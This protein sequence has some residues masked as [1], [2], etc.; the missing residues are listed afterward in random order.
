MHSFLANLVSVEWI[1]YI[2][3]FGLILTGLFIVFT[4]KNLIKIIIGLDMA[5]TG[6]NILIVAAGYIKGNTELIF[7]KVSP[8]PAQMTDP[9]PQ[10]LVLTS[11]VIGFGVT[12]LALALVVRLYQKTGSLDV[13]KIRGL[14]W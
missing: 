2:A 14:K 9:V 6:V 3:S 12:A 5:E 11:I 4:D 13:S 10:A 1:I 8:A 7:L